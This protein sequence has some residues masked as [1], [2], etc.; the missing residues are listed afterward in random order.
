MRWKNVALVLGGSRSLIF[1]ALSVHIPLRYREV[2]QEQVV[3]PFFL[4]RKG[5]SV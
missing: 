4:G 1:F 2:S 3:Q 5:L